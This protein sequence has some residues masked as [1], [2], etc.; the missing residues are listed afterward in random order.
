MS[1][2][3]LSF[4]AA[5][6]AVTA[7]ASSSSDF[8]LYLLS[9]PSLTPI[10]KIPYSELDIYKHIIC[11]RKHLMFIVLHFPQIQPF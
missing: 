11:R 10:F 3:K 9:S 8:Q 4:F 5:A 7:A 2:E 1:Q 6:A